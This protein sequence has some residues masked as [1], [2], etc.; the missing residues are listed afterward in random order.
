VSTSTG[1]APFFLEEI[2]VKTLLQA[3]LP[4][5]VKDVAKSND[6]KTTALGTA[7]ATLFAMDIDYG[8]LVN[9][10]RAEIGKAIAAVIC[11][12]IGYYSNK[13]DKTAPPK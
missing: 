13:P 5:V 11:F 6:T 2:S 12:A 7:A 10:D 9:G 3:L 1:P 4:R 8:K